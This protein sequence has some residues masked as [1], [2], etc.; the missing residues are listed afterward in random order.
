MASP[1]LPGSEV[2]GLS[3]LTPELKASIRVLIVDDERT[4]RESCAS[5]LRYEGYQ[6]TICT[7]GDEARETLRKTKFDVVLIDLYM[8]EVPGMKL[9]RTCLESHRDTIV[10]IITGN[11]RYNT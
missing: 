8:S 5:V 9:L 7:R 10:I 11:P 3:H 2:A 4:L 1:A 6:V